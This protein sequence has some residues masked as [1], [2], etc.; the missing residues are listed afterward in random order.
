[1]LHMEN[2]C[3][4]FCLW[5]S[6]SLLLWENCHCREFESFLVP[7]AQ[8]YRL[9]VFTIRVSMHRISLIKATSM[10]VFYLAKHAKKSIT[11]WH[12]E[13]THFLLFSHLLLSMHNIDRWMSHTPLNHSL[14]SKKICIARKRTSLSDRL[15]RRFYSILLKFAECSFH[16]HFTYNARLFNYLWWVST[17]T[18][19]SFRWRIA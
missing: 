2:N 13:H 14:S 18:F 17:F 1:M 10:N 11:C 12:V 15:K 5:F 7:T 8:T 6:W 3:V 19:F 9:H 16:P 4:R